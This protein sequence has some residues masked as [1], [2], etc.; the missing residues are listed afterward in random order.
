MRSSICVAEGCISR[1]RWNLWHARSVVPRVEINRKCRMNIFGTLKFLGIRVFEYLRGV[2]D[3]CRVF[4]LEID[5]RCVDFNLILKLP[6][7]RS[8]VH[9]SV[10]K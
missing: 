3:H 4:L 1:V 5:L 7:S 8:M 9:Y 10:V 2:S 6:Y